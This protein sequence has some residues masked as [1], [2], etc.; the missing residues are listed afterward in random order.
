MAFLSSRWTLVATVLAIA[1]LIPLLSSSGYHLRVASLI[2]VFALA[3]IGLNLLMGFAGQVSLGHAG[4]IGIGAYAVAIGPSLGVSGFA[5]VWIG[6]AVSGVL[7]LIVGRPIL[8][9][10]GAICQIKLISDKHVLR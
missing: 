7:A 8:R 6:A 10:K 2:F 3:A 4:F 5:A 9:L 1:V